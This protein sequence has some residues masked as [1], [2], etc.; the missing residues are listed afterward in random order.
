M[1]AL[2]E[3]ADAMEQYTRRSNLVFH[4]FSEINGGNED[5]DAKIIALVNDEMDIGTPLQIGDIARSHR[6][7]TTRPGARGRLIIVRF[8]SDRVRDS[9]YRARVNLKLFNRQHRDSPV[10]INDDLTARGA[11][12]AFDCR[13]LKKDKRITDTWT[14]NGKILIKDLNNKVNEIKHPEQ[15]G[16]Y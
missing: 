15:L 14:F 1:F 7:G 10:F 2:E 5:M 16:H 9:V 12:M 4:G 6:L 11:N 8:T 3:S 13:R